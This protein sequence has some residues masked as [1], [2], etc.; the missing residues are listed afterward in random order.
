MLNS[1]QE[2]AV[3]DIVTAYNN[4]A[5]MM[6]LSGG[7]GTGKTYTTGKVVRRFASSGKTVAVAASTNHAIQIAR[8]T[9]INNGWYHLVSWWGTAHKLL[10]MTVSNG[11]SVPRSASKAGKYDVVIVDEASMLSFDIVR[12]IRHDSAF[13]LFVGDRNQ[14]PPIGEDEPVAFIAA[15]VKL[16]KSIRHQG[17]PDLDAL[18][19]HAEAAINDD[20]GGIPM[21]LLEPFI[22]EDLRSWE[23]GIG[24]SKDEVAI[25][26]TNLEA[27]RLNRLIRRG[28]SREYDFGDRLIF[29]SPLYRDNKLVVATN[30]IARIDGA[31]KSY[32]NDFPTW[33]LRVTVNGRALFIQVPDTEFDN[34]NYAKFL[35]SVGKRPPAYSNVAFAYAITAHRSQGGEYDTVHVQM[36]DFMRC[37]DDKTRGKLAYVAFSRAKENLRLYLGG[38]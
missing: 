5:V 25:S 33:Q 1:E 4:G 27:A 19:K 35:K 21:S 7:P 8:D 22:I 36:S 28:S 9:A 10:G 30:S 13:A 17:N 11:K 15:G 12:R 3:D 20:L 34:G 31:A 18:V 26:F 6:T 14:L 38:K 24:K 32:Q 23:D 37:Q 16:T 29:K 2:Q